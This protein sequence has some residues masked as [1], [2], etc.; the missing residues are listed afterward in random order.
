MIGTLYTSCFSKIKDGKGT[1]ISVARHVPIWIS[2]GKYKT[3]LD[4][5][6]I[7]LAPSTSLLRKW[8]NKLITWDEYIK[9]YIHDLNNGDNIG[10]IDKE[11]NFIC[12]LLDSGEDV[13]I[14]CY[15]SS[16]N[17]YCHRHILGKI[18]EKRGYQV[19]EI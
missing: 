13:T 8:K 4:F 9:E 5:I 7:Y 19:T 2:Q 16:K 11:F 10:N 3:E 17:S 12:D 6:F 1:K 14:Y 18:F 15:E